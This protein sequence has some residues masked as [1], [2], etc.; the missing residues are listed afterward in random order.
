MTSEIISSV[1]EEIIP[2]EKRMKNAIASK[3][4]LYPHEILVLDYPSSY[5]TEGNSFQGFWWY[6]YGVRNVDK[7]LHSVLDRGFLKIGDLQSAIEKE[8]AVVLKEELKKHGLKGSGKKTELVQR[9][10]EAVSYEELNSRFVRRTYQLT[11][12]GKQALDE[13]GYV[14]YIHRHRLEDLDIWSLNRIIHEPSYMPYRDKIWDYINKRSMKHFAARNFGLYRNCRY[15]M[16]TFLMEEKKIKDGLGM[17]SEVVF[18][19]LR[20]LGNCYD[21]Q[22]LDIYA[23]NFSLT[24]TLQLQWHPV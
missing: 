23:Q 17:L 3:H 19:D 4:C 14:S 1:A 15:D 11:E 16:S 24:N 10:M 5:Y 7:C 21:P 20:G 6:R 12:F 13:E 8:T 22:F 18:Y 2:V 9:L